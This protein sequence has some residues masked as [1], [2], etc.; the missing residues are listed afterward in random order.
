[1]IRIPLVRRGV[2]LDPLMLFWNVS[3]LQVYLC[4]RRYDEAVR[5]FDF[6]VDLVPTY[7]QA[8][9]FGGLS[10]AALGHMKEAVAALELGVTHSGGTPYAIGYLGFVLAKAGRRDEA[11]AQ[12]RTLLERA[13]HAY[14]PALSVASIHAGL[15][16]RNNA[17]IWIERAY[18]QKTCGSH[19]ISDRC[20]SSMTCGPTRA[21][22]ISSAASGCELS[23]RVRSAA[24][25]LRT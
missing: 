6:A 13:E 2:E 24:P 19:G 10:H 22:P 5:Q 16:D 12:L 7:S 23:R 11:E 3:L 18:E 4:S 14:V 20:S 1:M 25:G 9:L 15:N 8:H 17:L 21:S